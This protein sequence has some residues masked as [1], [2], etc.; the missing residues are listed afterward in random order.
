MNALVYEMICDSCLVKWMK[1]Q[2][3][4]K[5]GILVESNLRPQ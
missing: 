3:K 5:K 2:L 4:T 1:E